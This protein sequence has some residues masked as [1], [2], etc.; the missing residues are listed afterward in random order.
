M[1]TDYT[2]SQLLDLFTRLNNAVWPMPLVAYGLG[3]A[4]V[5]LALRREAWSGQVVLLILAFF[6]LWLGLVF[7]LVYVP[8]LTSTGW[9]GGAVLCAV[10]AVLFAAVGL[11]SSFAFRP[12]MDAYSVLGALGV[13]YGLL[14]YPAVE[15]LL[16]RGYPQTAPFGLVP[17][18]TTV[19]TLGL[20][21]W[22]APPWRRALLVIPILYGLIAVIPVSKGVV[23]D[24]G[25]VAFSIIVAVLAVYR[26]RP[27]RPEI[28]L[29]G[30]IL[31]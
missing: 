14:G 19:F 31:A 30:G 9:L 22:A 29:R 6:W 17:C 2:L 8:Q 24:L 13:L 15:Y 3:V 5:F 27:V 28:D 23:E 20:L 21:L 12:R 11:R 10:Q 4:A 26:P 18:P 7:Y 16:G 1:W 25:L